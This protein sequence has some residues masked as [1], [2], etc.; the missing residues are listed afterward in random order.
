MKGPRGIG[1]MESFF[2]DINLKGKGNEKED[3]DIVMG[4]L[5]H[6]AHR[7]FPRMQFDEALQKIEKLGS[8]KEVSV[9]YLKKYE[10]ISKCVGHL[11][12]ITI[13]L[14]TLQRSNPMVV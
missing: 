8:K 6:W 13:V 2:S 3:L 12:H 1:I 5:E 9:R 4:R 10:T 14:I 11:A 7:L